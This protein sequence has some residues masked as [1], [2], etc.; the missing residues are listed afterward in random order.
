MKN[1]TLTLIAL[2][3]IPLGMFAD[4]VDFPILKQTQ[5]VIVPSYIGDNWKE[6]PV[7][8]LKLKVKKDGSIEDVKFLCG[9]KKL[10]HTVMNAMKNSFVIVSPAKENGVP[11][12]SFVKVPLILK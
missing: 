10:R 9:N 1:A 11:I 2:M 5:E 7:V 8:K 3:L 6:N 4:Q 12:D